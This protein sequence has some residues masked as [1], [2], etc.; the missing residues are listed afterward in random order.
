MHTR[1]GYRRDQAP[2]SVPLLRSTNES[3]D[4]FLQHDLFED[5]RGKIIGRN[6]VAT[7]QANTSEDGSCAAGAYSSHEG[8]GVSVP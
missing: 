3:K 1:H 8:E 7:A 6:G 2:A 5:E 4:N